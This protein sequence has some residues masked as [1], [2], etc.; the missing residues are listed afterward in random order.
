MRFFTDKQANIADKFLSNEVNNISE[1]DV[2]EAIEIFK[3]QTGSLILKPNEKKYVRLGVLIR[4]QFEDISENENLT[5]KK[6]AYLKGLTKDQILEA[7]SS[8]KVNYNIKG[9]EEAKLI[10]K[11]IDLR[12]RQIEDDNKVKIRNFSYFVNDEDRKLLECAHTSFYNI[13]YSIV[14]AMNIEF[15]D[16]SYKIDGYL[17]HIS[18]TKKGVKEFRNKLGE[19]IK[20]VLDRIPQ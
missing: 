14:K 2:R 17:I 16:C 12:Q 18:T 15:S 9:M 11:G 4:Q 5:E 7:I 6:S 20:E 1:K 13:Y 10:E 3:K 19:K 8:F